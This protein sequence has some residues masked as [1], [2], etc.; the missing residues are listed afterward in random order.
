[1]ILFL[2]AIATLCK[3]YNGAVKEDFRRWGGEDAG[4]IN[5]GE[6]IDHGVEDGVIPGGDHIGQVVIT[7]RVITITKFIFNCMLSILRNNNI[8]SKYII[9]NV[10]VVC[11]NYRYNFING[12]K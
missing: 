7:I 1:M 2:I 5:G 11:F 3:Q 9:Q 12:Y 10:C 4:A 8:F 6:D